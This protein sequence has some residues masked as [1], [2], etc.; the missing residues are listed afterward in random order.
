MD[1]C[2][3]NW[4]GHFL[5]GRK[6]VVIRGSCSEWSCVTSGTPQGTILGS[7]L[8]LLHINDITE[9]VPTLANELVNGNYVL[10]QI[11]GNLSQ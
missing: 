11:N 6:R 1:G 3:L 7:L 9:C 2:L 8:F 10:M 5:V 4:L